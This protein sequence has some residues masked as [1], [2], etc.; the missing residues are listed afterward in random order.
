MSRYVGPQIL[1]EVVLGPKV[2]VTGEL[3][4]P[5]DF[6]LS[7]K[8]E[9]SGDLAC[10][11]VF[12]G[13]QRISTR[14]RCVV[15]SDEFRASGVQKPFRTT[16]IL[17]DAPFV[18]VKV[19]FSWEVCV[20]DLLHRTPSGECELFSSKI[21]SASFQITNTLLPARNSTQ[22][23]Q[24]M[25]TAL[26]P[27]EGAEGCNDNVFFKDTNKS[28]YME[29]TVQL[30]E[31]ASD[32][33]A[34]STKAFLKSKE[35]QLVLCSFTEHGEPIEWKDTVCQDRTQPLIVQ[36]R[37]AGA[38]VSFRSPKRPY[39]R[40][41]GS[42]EEEEEEENRATSAHGWIRF[43]VEEISKGAW[44]CIKVQ[45]TGKL[46]G[47]KAAYSEK[48]RVRSKEPSPKRKR[49]SDSAAKAFFPEKSKKKQKIVTPELNATTVVSASRLNPSR[50][51]KSRSY[52][53]FA[54][55]EVQDLGS[56][57]SWG[58]PPAKRR[59][60]TAA[61]AKKRNSTSLPAKRR[62]STAAPA[63]KKKSASAHLVSPFVS[64]NETTKSLV[65]DPSSEFT[66]FPVSA[67]TLPESTTS[68]LTNL[69]T[70]LPTFPPA[71]PQSIQRTLS[72]PATLQNNNTGVCFIEQRLVK[73]TVTTSLPVNPTGFKLIA[74]A[75]LPARKPQSGPKSKP[76]PKKISASVASVTP[77]PTYNRPY[78]QPENVYNFEG[79]LVEKLTLE[80]GKNTAIMN[81]QFYAFD[82]RDA[83]S[84]NL[85]DLQELRNLGFGT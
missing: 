64:A 51:G 20:E 5:L 84:A 60:S 82:A 75:P 43:R 58:S 72:S 26:A 68:M 66:D 19:E 13:R 11:V 62:R 17:P 69:P 6:V 35:V 16:V 65:V 25:T 32:K 71:F 80:D 33:S 41:L 83:A 56:D 73:P 47:V 7:K 54:G 29:I 18:P 21:R 31:T 53:E 30:T 38:G 28:S 42:Y 15:H 37:K 9:L 45:G 23:M 74:P 67:F 49:E 34:I 36:E 59:K 63:E 57:T 14:L 39:L 44:W 77:P 61:P 46:A 1:L 78:F 27:R 48:F 79:H 50:P 10:F 40:L 12:V 3:L 55:D 22:N 81:Q 70:N 52:V 24:Y 4:T 8:R 85:E 76:M 2:L